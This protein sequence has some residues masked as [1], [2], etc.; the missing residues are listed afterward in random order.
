MNQAANG[1]ISSR[2]TLNMLGS[3]GQFVKRLDIYTRIPLTPAMVEIVV[4]ILVELL[5]TL[6]SVTKELKQR[7]SSECFLADM[8]PFSAR[9]SRHCEEVF[10]GEG[11][12]GG[13]A[14]TGPTHAR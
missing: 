6:A 3:I 13:P 1:V 14:E 7:R 11:H 8:I 12:Q 2:D 5:S 9:R 4:K 10:R